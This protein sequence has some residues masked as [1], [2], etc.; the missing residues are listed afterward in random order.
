M[1]DGKKWD[2]TQH[3]GKQIVVLF[4]FASWAAPSTNDMPSVLRFVEEY[5]QQGVVFYAIDVGEESEAARAFL[6]TQEYSHPVVLDPHQQAT[7]AYRV[8]SLPV[9]VLIG[10]DGT[11]QAVHV[12]TSPEERALIGADLRKLVTG[13]QLAPVHERE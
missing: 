9:T 1:L 7:A 12:G 13:T 6:E 5:E 4:F 11:L 10:K 8:T 3:R 2:L